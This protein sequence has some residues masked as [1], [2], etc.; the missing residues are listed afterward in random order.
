[1]QRLRTTV[2]KVNKNIASRGR[3][4]EPETTSDTARASGLHRAF[5]QLLGAPVGSTA[6]GNPSDDLIVPVPF[7]LRAFRERGGAW[8][9]RT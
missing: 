2:T 4:I 8:Q 3:S 9:M 1:M 5:S 6:D 7:G